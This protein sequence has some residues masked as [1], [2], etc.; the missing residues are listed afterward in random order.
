MVQKVDR[1][2]QL[3]KNLEKERKYKDGKIYEEL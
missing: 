1:V 2:S 3:N